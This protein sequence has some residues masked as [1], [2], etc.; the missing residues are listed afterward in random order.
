MRGKHLIG[1]IVVVAMLALP[2]IAL[3]ALARPSAGRWKVTSGGFTVNH[4]GTSVS[5]FHI[6]GASC[7]LGKLRVLGAQKLRLVTEA[8]VSNWIVGFADPKRTNPHGI[9]GVVPQRVK[10]R[11]GDKLMNARLD[12]VFAV[13]GTA[14]DNDGDLV[15]Q[16]CDVSFFATR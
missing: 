5:G 4:A 12:I 6:D 2:A 13:G 15:I 10:V 16:G 1:L 11:S 8:G 3:A 14:R 7:G 9:S